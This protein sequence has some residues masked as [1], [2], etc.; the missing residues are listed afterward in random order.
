MRR[1][2][3]WV[4]LWGMGLAVAL[5]MFGFLVVDVWRVFAERQEL[6]G[7]ADSA[8]IAGATAID[9]DVFRTTGAVIL[10]TDD[11]P[12]RATQYLVN[13]AFNLAGEVTANITVVGAPPEDLL[14]VTLTKEFQFAL[15]GPVVGEDGIT[16]SVTAFAQPGERVGP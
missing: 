13:N 2:D 15:L 16:F 7:L 1:E 11:A 9:V 3:G 14:S 10:D 8:A 5:V 4:T 6:G 12:A